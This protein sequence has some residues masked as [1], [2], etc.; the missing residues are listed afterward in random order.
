MHSIYRAWPSQQEKSY[1]GAWRE[2]FCSFLAI[3]YGD[4]IGGYA[5]YGPSGD[6]GT[7]NKAPPRHSYIDAQ[8]PCLLDRTGK[9]GKFARLGMAAILSDLFWSLA[10]L[11]LEIDLHLSARPNV[12][13]CFPAP[14]PR[15]LYRANFE[16]ATLQLEISP[17]LHLCSDVKISAS[18]TLS[19]G[20]SLLPRVSLVCPGQNASFLL[21][22]PLKKSDH[23]SLV[24][25]RQQDSLGPTYRQH[26][27][28]V[29]GLS[30][31]Q[32]TGLA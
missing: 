4:N 13:A 3:Q 30:R 22:S 15:R 11:F 32:R 17:P 18:G 21:C 20:Q 24:D 9:L 16:S 14:P 1:T 29:C 23:Y 27:A 6:P 19:C 26:A 28:I 8:G 5:F 7:K 25:S 10:R 12:S 31:S 2:I